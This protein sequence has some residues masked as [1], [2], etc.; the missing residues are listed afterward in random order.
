MKR[1]IFFL[2]NLHSI[3][4]LRCLK[5][6]FFGPLSALY[7]RPGLYIHHMKRTL[8]KNRCTHRRR[9]RRLGAV[10]PQKFFD[11]QNSGR[12]L[13]NNSGRLARI[14]TEYPHFSTECPTFCLKLPETSQN[15]SR[16]LSAFPHISC[17]WITLEFGQFLEI[18]AEIVSAPLNWE[19]PLRQCTCNTFD[20][21]NNMRLDLELH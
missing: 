12:K 16:A 9:R 4:I 5:S 6:S 3:S 1:G 8:Q 18:R 20:G 14:L 15:F 7:H 19:V 10:G 11:T 21:Q 17:L 13:R 2:Y